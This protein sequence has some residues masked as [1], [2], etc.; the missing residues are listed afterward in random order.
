M[1]NYC[2]IC[3]QTVPS[4]FYLCSFRCK[5]HLCNSCRIEIPLNDYSKNSEFPLLVYV[6]KP[7][8]ITF[9][10]FRCSNMCL[11]LE[12]SEAHFEIHK[13]P[14][15][16][17]F[18]EKQQNILLTIKINNSLQNFLLNDLVE[19]VNEFLLNPDAHA[20]TNIITSY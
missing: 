15:Y 10:T 12:M 16:K 9:F 4:N 11:Y 7:E 8:Y 2:M 17:K 14:I 19:I 13:V 5:R 6:H 20:N 3:L 18:S 1:S